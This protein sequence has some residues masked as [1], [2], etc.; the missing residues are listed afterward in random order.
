M[1]QK[2]ED[3]TLQATCHLMLKEVTLQFV[4]QILK[5][6]LARIRPRKSRNHH[7]K[8]CW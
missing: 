7:C 3:Q 4:S 5:M 8:Q 6:V 2:S 1:T